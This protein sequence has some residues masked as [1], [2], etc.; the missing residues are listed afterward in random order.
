MREPLAAGS[1]DAMGSNLQVQCQKR[2]SGSKGDEFFEVC[3]IVA[4]GDAYVT[5][6]VGQ[7]QMFAAQYYR[8]DKPRRWIN[9]GGLGT[10]GFGLPAALGVQFAHPDA[11]VACVTG[12]GSIVMCIQE[13]SVA[14]QYDLPV[15][16]I[17]LNNKNSTIN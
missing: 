15:K 11:T 5:S 2:F 1:V 12:E 6:D 13:L 17:N 16:I 14:K 10:M 3:W 8:F 7:H 9:S 4:H